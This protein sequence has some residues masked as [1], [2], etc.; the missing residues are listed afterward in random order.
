MSLPI[1]LDCKVTI[2]LYIKDEQRLGFIDTT[3][4]TLVI[5]KTFMPPTAKPRRTACL[6][7]EEGSPHRM[8]KPKAEWL[9]FLIARRLTMGPPPRL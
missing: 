7:N 3:I 8:I 5:A 2:L 9:S 6:S 4:R 1:D